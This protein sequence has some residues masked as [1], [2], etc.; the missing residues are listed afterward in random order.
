[1]HFKLYLEFDITVYKCLIHADITQCTCTDVIEHIKKSSSK[2]NLCKN[3]KSNALLLDRDE[4][5]S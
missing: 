2:K 4:L 5:S 3:Y 1:M